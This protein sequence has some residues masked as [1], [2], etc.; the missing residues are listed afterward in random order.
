MYVY[1]AYDP[2]VMDGTCSTHEGYM[3]M[4]CDV[5]CYDGYK[6]FWFSKW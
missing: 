6:F 5:F 2:R 1:P 3:I 4:S